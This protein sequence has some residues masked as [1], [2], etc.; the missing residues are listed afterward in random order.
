M[1]NLFQYLINVRTQY[2]K[3]TKSKTSIFSVML[4]L[5]QYL[6]N[7]RTQYSKR[8]KSKIVTP[9]DFVPLPLG[10]TEINSV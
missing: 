1:L 9:P 3:R 4:N 7:V 5:F 10:D 6:I 2:S 8:T